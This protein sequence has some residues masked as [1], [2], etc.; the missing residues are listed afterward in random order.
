MVSAGKGVSEFVHIGKSALG[1]LSV[2]ETT[3]SMY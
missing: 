1:C 3:V 2:Y